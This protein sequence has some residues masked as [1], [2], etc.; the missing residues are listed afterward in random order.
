MAVKTL[1]A[2][3]IAVPNATATPLIVSLNSDP[4]AGGGVAAPIGS[5]LLRTDTG[6]LYV[7]TGAPNTSWTVIP[8]TVA[9]SGT[10]GLFGSGAD[11]AFTFD[12]A[13]TL[14]TVN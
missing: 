2:N 7:K 14:T 9:A 12:G 3:T 6:Q 8:T 13:A 11:G 4:T 10:A 1:E 5:F